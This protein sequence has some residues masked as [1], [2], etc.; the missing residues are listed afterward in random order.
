MNLLG[1]IGSRIS[2][3]GSPGRC[4]LFIMPDS[5]S[6]LLI[7]SSP[8]VPST[9]TSA[10]HIHVRNMNH[11]NDN[12]LLWCHSDPTATRMYEFKTLIQDKYHQR[13][14]TYE[15]LR[16]WTITNLSAFW[17]QVWH[18]TQIRAS[19]PFTEVNSSSGQG[20]WMHSSN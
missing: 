10:A 7:N 5:V 17:E 6:C 12:K 9:L 11:D 3:L 8:F 2:D 16:Q 1:M 15:H 4:G 13:L 18:F 20:P 19:S 14:D